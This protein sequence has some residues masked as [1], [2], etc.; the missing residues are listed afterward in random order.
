MT[1]NF[2]LVPDQ[3]TE[4]TKKLAELGEALRSSFQ[5]LTGVLDQHDGCWGE[6]DIG[7]SFEQNYVPHAEEARKNA[8]QTTT[9]IVGLADATSQA[10]ET[11]QE[12]DYESARQIDAST[13][14]NS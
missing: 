7:K 8:G 1:D 3:A 13:G 10:V 6:D 11:F 5:T 2:R 12:V 14:Q 9:A 4:A